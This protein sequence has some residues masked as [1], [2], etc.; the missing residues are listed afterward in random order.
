[1]GVIIIVAGIV[2]LAAA[3]IWLAANQ[4][5]KAEERR[6]Y[7]RAAYRIIREQYLDGAIRNGEKPGGYQ[8]RGRLMIALKVKGNKGLGYV[9]D[10]SREIVIGRSMETSDVCLQDLAVSGSQCKIFMYEDQLCIQDLD[11]ANGTEIQ[12]RWK[13]REQLFGNIGFLY[14]KSKIQVGST[15]F[16]VTVFYCDMAAE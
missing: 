12:S 2:L 10:P 5:V 11:S 7:Y 4:K 15:C 6:K 14:N 9:F 16:L 3:G 8:D 13:G 1:M